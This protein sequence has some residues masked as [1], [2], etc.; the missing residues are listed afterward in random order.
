MDKN[1]LLIVPLIFASP[2]SANEALSKMKHNL[3]R[4]KYK[5]NGK[6]MNSLKLTT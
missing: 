6:L 5:T 3:S 1:R 2:Y 4:D